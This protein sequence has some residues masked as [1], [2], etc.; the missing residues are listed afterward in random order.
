MLRIALFLVIGIFLGHE[1]ADAVVPSLWLAGLAF[2][3][4]IAFFLFR[5]PILQTACLLLSV[6]LLGAFLVSRQDA[7][8]SL[9]PDDDELVHRAVLVS[10]PVERGKIVR[11]DL[12]LVEGRH[13]GRLV[14]AS[15]LRDT[16]DHR[17]RQ[18]NVGDGIMMRSVLERPRQF[19]QSNFNYPL[20]LRCHGFSATTF[21]YW[22]AWMKESV[23]LHSMSAVERVRLRALMLRQRLLSSLR[24]LNID[25]ENMAV[26]SAMA[27]GEKSGLSRELRDAYSVSG[28]S[29]IL[30]LSGL[31]LGIIYGL[32]SL[33]FRFR[34]F[35]FVG[36]LLILT[37]IWTY[38]FIVGLTPSVTR[39]ATMISIYSL[40]GLLRRDRFSL[41]TFGLTAVIML[42]VNPLSLYDVGFQLS[43]AAVFFILLLFKPIYSLVSPTVLERYVPLRWLWS[44]VVVSCTAQL[45]AAPLVIYHFGTFS[46]YFLLANL[47]I[48]PL[49]TLI[50]YTFPFLLLLSF[51]PTLQLSVAGWFSSLL[52]LQS[53]ALRWISSLPAAQ[54]DGIRISALQ[55]GL[56][57]FLI[58]SLCAIVWKL[59]RVK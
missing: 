4:G 21:V 28:A 42:L 22:D 24:V 56:I 33:L 8:L 5:Y 3:V 59:R 12:R 58:F 10:Q 17:Y 15:I 36:E 49:T 7:R 57:Y 50:L 53:A 48:I 41:N 38:A 27:L 34:R 31:H 11:C 20:Y 32:L 35:R 6:S 2:S 19:R 37:A 40:M 30:A 23:R 18:L 43:F 51:A 45:G 52:T 1:M 46:V 26:L 44:L 55:L 39:A 25:A 16:V 54:I 29:H 47:V 9:S 14:K 13:A